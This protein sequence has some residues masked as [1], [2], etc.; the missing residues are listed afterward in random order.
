MRQFVLAAGMICFC[1]FSEV[2][3]AQMVFSMIDPNETTK[4]DSI[5]ELRFVAQYRLQ[6]V[7]DTAYPDK[8][9]EETMMLKVG[10]KSAL[11]YSYTRFVA[12]SVLRVT[13]KRNNGRVHIDNKDQVQGSI[14][15][16]ICK[17]YPSGKV[18]TLDQV[19][20]SKFRCEEENDVPEWELLPDTMTFLS[21][22]CLKASCTF[23][24]RD[25]EVWY[26]P[27]IARSEGPWKL[28]GLPGF[29]VKAEDSRGHYRFECTGIEQSRPNE[30]LLISTNGG[31]SVSRKNLNKVYE[32][33]AK[34]PIGYVTSTSPNMKIMIRNESGESIQPKDTPYN[35]IELKE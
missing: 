28:H 35:P 6:F 12:D 1:L 31:E 18:T 2:A 16:R 23:K 25:Y 14:S 21:Y 15:Y 4:A 24:G 30:P 32:R 3:T 33:Y 10:A 27:E 13:M 5:D 7:A 26:T 19:A 20:S 9:T 34:D 29:I 22:S 11:F 17:N 8:L